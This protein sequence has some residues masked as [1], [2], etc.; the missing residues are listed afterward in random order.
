MFH[1]SSELVQAT[2]DRLR[3]IK[4]KS[5]YLRKSTAVLQKNDLQRED[6][7]EISKD[8][9]NFVANAGKRD[10]ELEGRKSKKPYCEVEVRQCEKK[11]ITD[12]EKKKN[13]EK[14]IASTGLFSFYRTLSNTTFLIL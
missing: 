7:D 4:P 12:V 1:S 14:R 11:E 9:R 8:M 6:F 3:I 13:N 2:E 5:R 10:K